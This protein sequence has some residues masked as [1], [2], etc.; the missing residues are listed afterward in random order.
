MLHS[1][2]NCPAR[3]ERQAA[4]SPPSLSSRRIGTRGTEGEST[5]SRGRALL[6]A[7]M[8]VTFDQDDDGHNSIDDDM[9]DLPMSLPEQWYEWQIEL[10]D[11][12]YC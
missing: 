8:M 7:K 11:C 12:R 2:T 9:R 10:T 5:Q 1:Q 6:E 3:L 4:L